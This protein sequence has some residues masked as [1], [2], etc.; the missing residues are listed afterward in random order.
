MRPIWKQRHPDLFYKKK[1]P[2]IDIHLHGGV[3]RAFHVPGGD[4]EGLVAEM[5]ACGVDLGVVSSHCAIASDYRLGNDITLQWVRKHPDRLLAYCYINPNY[6]AEIEE[7]LHRCFA[8]GLCRG[9]KIHPELNGDYPMDG[10]NYQ[11]MWRYAAER[12]LPVLF[13]TYFGGDRLEVIEWLAGEYETATFLVG[14]CAFDLGLEKAVQMA[15]RRPNMVLDITGPQRFNGVVEYLVGNLG[16]DRVAY[17]S[18]MPFIDLGTMLGAVLH[19]G[20]SEEEKEQVLW[21]TAARILNLDL[22][23]YGLGTGQLT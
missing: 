17:G 16:A 18:D 21:R 8:T 23:S 22:S 12:R 15:R 9:I 6:P 11:G 10:R 19:A 4:G 7:E 3:Y 14:H 1:W 13:H 5:D 20:I 2:I